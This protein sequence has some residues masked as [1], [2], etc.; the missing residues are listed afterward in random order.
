MF[1]RVFSPTLHNKL[2]LN[3]LAQRSKASSYELYWNAA[4]LN[5]KR[6]HTGRSKIADASLENRPKTRRLEGGGD[7]PLIL[8]SPPAWPMASSPRKTLPV[9]ILLTARKGPA[10]RNPDVTADPIAYPK[11][12]GRESALSKGFGRRRFLQ[13]AAWSRSGAFRRASRRVARW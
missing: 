4:C 9:F 12:Y 2:K 3:Q 10:K 13:R 5:K 8:F 11:D 1:G 7:F 6:T